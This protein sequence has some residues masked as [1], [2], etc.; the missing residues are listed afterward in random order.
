MFATFKNAFE[1]LLGREGKHIISGA[2]GSSRSLFISELQKLIQKKIVIITSTMRRSYEVQEELNFFMDAKVRVFPHW[3]TL[4][5]RAVT[6]S[7]EIMSERISILVDLLTHNAPAC[8]ILPVRAFV[9]KVIPPARLIKHTKEIR[10]GMSI[11]LEEIV[12]HLYSSGYRRAPVTEHTGEYSVHGGIIDLFSPSERYPVRIELDANLIFSLRLFDPE[13]QRKVRDISDVKIIPP[14]EN[15]FTDDYIHNGL[16]KL[17]IEANKRDVLKQER[18]ALEE[19]F[20]NDDLF[21]G[22]DFYYSYFCQL[23]PFYEYLSSD[24]LIILDNDIQCRQ[25]LD[26]FFAETQDIYQNLPAHNLYP[27]PEKIFLTP[28]ECKKYWNERVELVF[29]QQKS[30]GMIEVSTETADEFRGLV[31]HTREFPFEEL[32]SHL[33]T[34]LEEGWR[35]FIVM[36]TEIEVKRIMSILEPYSISMQYIDEHISKHLDQEI[37]GQK[38]MILKGELRRGLKLKEDKLLIIGEWDIFGEKSRIKPAPKIKGIEITDFSTL[39]IGDLVVHEEYGIG[40]YCGL[41]LIEQNNKKCEFL[42]IEYRDGDKLYVPVFR[43]NLIQKYRGVKD[44]LP[45]LHKLGTRRWE[46]EKN[47]VKKSLE[48][49]TANLLRLYARRKLIRG[50]S[51]P[52]PD[53]TYIE[54]EST[55]PYE[56]TPDQERA[57]NDVLKDME[58]DSPMDR[59]IC[60]DVG[61]GKTEVAIRA[62][63]KAIMAGKQAAVLVPTTIL[64]IQHYN[65]FTE[66]FKNYPIRTELLTRLK[67]PSEIEGIIQDIKDGKVDLVIGTH[68]LLMDDIVFKDL[69]LLIIDEE[70]RFGVTQKEK[71]KKLIEGVDVLSMT[72]TPIPRSLQMSI[73]G[74]R[75][76][77]VIYTPPPLRQSIKTFVSYFNDEIIRDAIVLEKLRGGQTFYIHNEIRDIEKRAQ[78]VKNIIPEARIGIAHGRLD[79]KILEKTMV[80]FVNK[81]I[82]ILISTSIIASGI[83]IPAANTI[84]VEN[85]HRF[86]LTDL[87]Q[88]RGR[89][90]RSKETAYGY[91]LIPE[92]ESISEDAQK[93][94]SAI[95]EYA[96]VGHGFKLAM[97]DLEI[98]GAGELLGTRQSGHIS[99][100]GFELYS[101]LLEETINELSNKPITEE[102]EPEI[103]INVESYI[104]IE[105]IPDIQ[106]RMEIYKKLAIAKNDDDLN[107]LSDELLDR[108]GKIPPSLLNLIQLSKL[109]NILSEKRITTFSYINKRC[110]INRSAINNENLPLLLK[111][112]VAE[113]LKYQLE[114]KNLIIFLRE[115]LDVFQ[116]TDLLKK[117]FNVVK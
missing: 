44:T 71:L 81:E 84:I 51:F 39:K 38:L 42:I 107:K 73:S 30:P 33:K 17:R 8:L 28:D 99:S 31:S 14:S 66:R 26:D 91:F 65:T 68:R 61:F 27:E 108:F 90:G 104:P 29:S 6:L 102:I 96:E 112:I 103:N 4:P 69:G 92:G 101:R 54:F 97:R 41:K 83:D 1:N 47:R 45:E 79:K 58:S 34:L 10:K 55:F 12:Q 115:A 32:A 77:S 88:L 49:L 60:G 116:L 23:I 13:T 11:E 20:L 3:G 48:E 67:K 113:N 24:F 57:I 21:P 46:N 82:D 22:K 111:A 93:R 53:N 37:V 76:M 5:Y 86:G 16:E 52:P 9:Q 100:I 59:L 109:R 70:H 2:L 35:I 114:K 19:K 7:Q 85:A 117:I 89:V 94:L 87:Y 15:I 98:R 18:K 43:L 62:A 80:A 74:I 95:Q 75:D 106:T 64:A 40:K 110:I 25:E 105:Y 63:F 36:P 56:E 50:F 78:Y 72:A